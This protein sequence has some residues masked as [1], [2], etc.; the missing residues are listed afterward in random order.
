MHEMS[1]ALNI[2]DIVSEEALRAEARSINSIEIEIGSISGV[3]ISALELALEAAVKGSS[4]ERTQI[5]IIPIQAT[6]RCTECNSTYTLTTLYE[7]CPTCSSLKF[8][9]VR[10][11]ELQIKSINVA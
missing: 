6:A 9:V 1:I 7:P 4:L 5:K 11:K 3:E 2:I 10:G 8:H